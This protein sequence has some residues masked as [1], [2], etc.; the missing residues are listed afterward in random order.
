MDYVERF[1]RWLDKRQDG[2]WIYTGN[3]DADGYGRLVRGGKW[4]RAHRYAYALTKG[5]IPDGMMVCHTCDNRPCCN[6]AHLFVGT[7]TD[8]NRDREAKG[9]GCKRREWLHGER[10]PMSK[11]TNAQRLEIRR[12][13]IA[14][15]SM[16]AMGRIFGVS[17]PSVRNMCLNGHDYT[18]QAMPDV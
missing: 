17:Y 9:R 16:R 10:S 12:R 18:A 4:V 11:L 6:P 15:E 2:C 1:W 14:G 8:N 5:P 13:V 7:A 3:K